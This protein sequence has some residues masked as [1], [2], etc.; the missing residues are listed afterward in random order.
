[1][2]ATIS[3]GIAFK[4]RYQFRVVKL[5]QFDVI[6]GINTIRHYKIEMRHDTSD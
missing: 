1:V 5:D 6:I 4:V 3:I 2:W